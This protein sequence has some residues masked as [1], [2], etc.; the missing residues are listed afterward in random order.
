M[1]SGSRPLANRSGTNVI[2]KHRPPK[3][4][5][6][7]EGGRR[8]W[9]QRRKLGRETNGVNA[10]SGRWPQGC[11]RMR[12]NNAENMPDDCDRQSA[13]MQNATKTMLVR[14]RRRSGGAIHVNYLL[15]CA[16]DAKKRSIRSANGGAGGKTN[17]NDLQQ[18]QSCNCHCDRSPPHGSLCFDRK[19]HCR[20]LFRFATRKLGYKPRPVKT[21]GLGSSRCGVASQGHSVFPKK[22][23]DCPSLPTGM[24]ASAAGREWKRQMTFE[25]RRP[26]CR[27][28]SP[29]TCPAHPTPLGEIEMSP[30]RGVRLT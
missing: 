7:R 9:R 10:I 27:R 25:C 18:Q 22:V 15:R 29:A 1:F 6:D 13:V 21:N 28:D 4:R 12:D 2:A 24:V 3:T 30:N 14:G 11:F 19:G 17:E 5:S 23:G 20:P 16:S 26:I 8:P